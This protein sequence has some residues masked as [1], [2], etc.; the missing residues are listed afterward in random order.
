MLKEAWKTQ[1]QKCEM[2]RPLLA[3]LSVAEHLKR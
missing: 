2:V 3:G 1:R